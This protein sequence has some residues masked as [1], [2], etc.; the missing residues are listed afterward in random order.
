MQNT[1]NSS[2]A[3]VGSNDFVYLFMVMYRVWMD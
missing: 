3:F 2:L 1:L